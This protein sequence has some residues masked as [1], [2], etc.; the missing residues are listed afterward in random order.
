M[1]ITKSILT[2]IIRE[3]ILREMMG[4]DHPI[5]KMRQFVDVGHKDIENIARAFKI[6]ASIKNN[7]PLQQLAYEYFLNHFGD[8][9]KVN[10]EGADLRGIVLNGASLQGAK[11]RGA[12]LEGA[13]LNGANLQGADLRGASLKG[14]NLQGADLT[15]A[16]LINSYLDKA[17]FTAADLTN[18]FMTNVRLNKTNFTDANLANVRLLPFRELLGSIFKGAKWNSRT[19]IHNYWFGDT[20][21]YTN[22][23]SE[24]FR[25]DN[26]LVQTDEVGP[27]NAPA[28]AVLLSDLFK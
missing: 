16:N 22:P 10:L 8:D 4:N 11:L 15:G 5:A 28:D 25:E 20:G 26:E 24:K 27:M 19:M 6:Y 14:A 21:E 9:G 2:K 12:N 1:K 13:I 17:N 23:N 3:E 7:A 18:S